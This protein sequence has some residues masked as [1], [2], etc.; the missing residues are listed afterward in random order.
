[1]RALTVIV[2]VLLILILIGEI[3]VGMDVAW[4]DNVFMLAARVFL[5]Q[6]KLGGKDKAPKPKKEKKNKEKDEEPKKEK[7]GLPPLPILKSAAELGFAMLGRLVSKLKV[8]LLRI[9]FTSAFDDPA[10]TAM[11]YGAV[12]T[13]MEALLRMGGKRIAH[14][15]LHV[16]ADF[17]S[18]E[19]K[20][21]LR[22]CITLKIRQ[23]LGAGLRFAFGFLRD[24]IRYKI[25]G[26]NDMHTE[27]MKANGQSVTG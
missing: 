5:F 9:H 11:A 25:S 17:E 19:M 26:K 15:D 8:D 20:L 21:D 13:S 14:P 23:I 27:R 10:V 6:I 22:I 12:G 1:M 16:D 24:L 4:K 7:R 3:P 2:I 18:K